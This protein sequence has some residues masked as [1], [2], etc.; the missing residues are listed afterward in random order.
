M[1]MTELGPHYLTL[2]VDALVSASGN[3]LSPNSAVLHTIRYLVCA[4]AARVFSQC[5]HKS[6]CLATSPSSS[7]LGFPEDQFRNRLFLMLAVAMTS[8]LKSPLPDNV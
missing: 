5:V 6:F 2:P 7:V 1:N 4:F 3:N 8:K